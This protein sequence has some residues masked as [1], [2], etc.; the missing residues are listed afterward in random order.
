[1]SRVEHAELDTK[2]AE[3]IED[4]HSFAEL[5]GV[6]A[7]EGPVS[8]ERSLV[9]M[10]LSMEELSASQKADED[11]GPLF[12]FLERRVAPDKYEMAGWSKRGQIYGRLFDSL[13]INSKDV[14]LYKKYDTRW[15]V[16]TTV[17]V[18]LWPQDLFSR[19]IA[20]AHRLVAHKATEATVAEAQ[21][22]GYFQH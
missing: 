6:N 21:R 11:I 2:L 12:R 18:A 20:Y 5:V 1:M 8:L 22:L 3:S 9:H 16:A 10:E 15:G 14:I 4:E 19:L 17:E 7:I 13:R